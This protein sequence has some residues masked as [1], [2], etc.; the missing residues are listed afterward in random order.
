M[1]TPII[2]SA[3][4]WVKNKMR[5]FNGETVS[6]SSVATNLIT[7]RP[8]CQEKLSVP[9]IPGHKNHPVCVAR[10]EWI[11]SPN[12]HPRNYHWPLHMIHIVSSLSDCNYKKNDFSFKANQSQY[13]PERFLSAT[14]VLTAT[15]A[16]TWDLINLPP[17]Y[18]PL[19]KSKTAHATLI[20]FFT[21][22]PG[23]LPLLQPRKA[24]QA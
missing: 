19:D 11:I 8:R 6:P 14:P 16:T 9:S 4:P 2:H 20:S 3:A 1:N 7:E 17:S 5:R 12:I 13:D 23:T 22:K 24:T 15:T 18:L 10:V 21:L